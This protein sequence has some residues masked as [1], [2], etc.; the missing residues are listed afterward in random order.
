MV[1]IETIDWGGILLTLI[2][3]LISAVVTSGIITSFV[4][5]R[6]RKKLKSGDRSGYVNVSINYRCGNYGPFERHSKILCAIAKP[7]K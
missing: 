1:G 2:K 7:S 6:D 3:P 4:I 5:Y